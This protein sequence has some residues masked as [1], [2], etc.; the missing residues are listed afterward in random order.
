MSQLDPTLFYDF[1]KLASI[2]KDLDFKYQQVAVDEFKV[3]LRDD[4]YLG[5][6]NLP[7]D[8]L[9]YMDEEQHTHGIH[10]ALGTYGY[11]SIHYLDILLLIRTGEIWIYER[12]YKKRLYIRWLVHCTEIADELENLESDEE[13]HVI[14]L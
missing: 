11:T 10:F 8:T 14:R 6:V 5:L 13:I 1:N 12:Y 2:C 7:D 4:I 3:I 9:I